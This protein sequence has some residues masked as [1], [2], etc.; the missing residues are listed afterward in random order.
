MSTEQKRYV[1]YRVK[2]GAEKF[3]NW[4]ED[5]AR[6]SLISEAFVIGEMSPGKTRDDLEDMKVGEIVLDTGT[7]NLCIKVESGSEW[8]RPSTPCPDCEGHLELRKKFFKI[9]SPKSPWKYLCS[10]NES[11]CKTVYAASKPGKISGE[12]VNA[13]TRNA[14]KL[15]TTM[16]E[17]LW[18]QAP[19]I[20]NW[21]GDMSEMHKVVNK[22]K[23]RA[24]RFLAHTMKEKGHEE[25][26]INKMD[27]PTLREAYK[28][29][30]NS[31]LNEVMRF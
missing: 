14:R 26:N 8:I 7:G 29:C 20:V 4:A 22:A 30:K 1:Y 19:D 10:R 28:I 25:G 2:K 13:E 23:A 17:R 9:G 21:D 5:D 6:K 12:P 15:T 18:K 24:Y 27:I 16:F 11:G 3:Q 31:D